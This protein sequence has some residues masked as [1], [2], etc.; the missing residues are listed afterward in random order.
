MTE[1]KSRANISGERL[2]TGVHCALEEVID[3]YQKKIYNL[4]LRYTGDK[5]E[6]F[7]LSQEIFFRLCRKIQ[8]FR[9]N[10]NFDAWFMRLAVNTAINYRLKLK[11]NPSHW[12]AEFFEKDNPVRNDTLKIETEALRQ[13]VFGLL[14]RLPKKERMAIILQLWECKKVREIADMMSISP[15]GV[16]SL[17]TRGRKRL[18]KMRGFLNKDCYKGYKNEKV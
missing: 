4:A 9:K 17:L 18:K 2:L 11:K 7:D 15:K 6:A 1:F 10:S 12:A 13:Q 16:E 3:L 8:L 5:V 14:T